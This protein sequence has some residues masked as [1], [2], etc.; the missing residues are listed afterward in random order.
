MIF[1]SLNFTKQFSFYLF[2]CIVLVFFFSPRFFY[3]FVITSFLFGWPHKHTTNTNTNKQKN[4][5][6]ST[7]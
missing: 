3:S 2:F 1:F 5:K 7:T 4:K 6:I